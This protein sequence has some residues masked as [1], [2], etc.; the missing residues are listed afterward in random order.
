MS[1]LA[2]WRPMLRGRIVFTRRTAFAPKG[3][4][5]RSHWKWSRADARVAISQAAAAAFRSLDLDVCVIPS[6]VMAVPPDPQRVEALRTHY[7]LRGG[8]VAGTAARSEERRV[9]KRGAV[10][11]EPGGGG[12]L[13]K[14]HH[15]HTYEHLTQ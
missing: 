4:P 11:V 6:A 12:I 1:V 3:R 5:G 2:L 7:G 8:T 14:T 9:G 10:R 13:T 15:Q